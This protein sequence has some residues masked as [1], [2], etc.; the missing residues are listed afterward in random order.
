MEFKKKK[1]FYSKG[2]SRVERGLEFQPEEKKKMKKSCWKKK[3]VG[4]EIISGDYADDV[5]NCMNSIMSIITLKWSCAN[6]VNVLSAAI[7]SESVRSVF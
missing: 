1:K 4:N 7:S 3:K 6:C 5:I 2:K